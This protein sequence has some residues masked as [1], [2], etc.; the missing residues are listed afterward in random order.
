M[1]GLLPCFHEYSVTVTTKLLSHGARCDPVPTVLPGKLTCF[2][3]RSM[4]TDGRIPL[5]G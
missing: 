4:R 1:A 3:F 5:R 2:I